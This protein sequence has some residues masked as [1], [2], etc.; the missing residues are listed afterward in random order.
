V[1]VVVVLTDVD[2]LDGVDVDDVDIIF[3]NVGGD[4]MEEEE[5]DDDDELEDED[6]EEKDV[7]GLE[8]SVGPSQICIGSL[9]LLSQVMIG[10]MLC[11]RSVFSEMVS[12]SSLD[13]VDDDDVGCCCV[14]C[15]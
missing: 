12:T 4:A 14:S 11:C 8:V 1:L 5:E 15:G 13:D 3:C 2:E 10:R 6:E 7:V 9:L